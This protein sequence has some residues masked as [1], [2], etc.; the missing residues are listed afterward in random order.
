[1]VLATRGV[2]TAL[3]GHP[4]VS[5]SVTVGPDGWKFELKLFAWEQ[6]RAKS[7]T[8]FCDGREQT[9]FA[10]RSSFP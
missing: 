6:S 3:A 8:A 7:S 10:S 4:V 5:D 2:K 9:Q 1:M